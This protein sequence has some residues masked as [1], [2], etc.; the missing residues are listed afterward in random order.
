MKLNKI[1]K[2]L[3]IFVFI[4]VLI[5]IVDYEKLI[6]YAKETDMALIFFSVIMIFPLYLIKSLRFYLLLK[7]QGLKYSFKNVL[8]IYFSTNFIGFITPG[9]IG[10]FA[11]A[12][13]L[14]QDIGITMAESMPTVIIDRVFDLYFLFI[15][16]LVGLAKL[17]I[18]GNFSNGLYIII[19]L[20]LISPLAI[21]I[22]S[23][24]RSIS[25]IGVLKTNVKKFIS[26]II[27]GVKKIINVRSVCIGFLLTIFAYASL[28]YQ[29]SLIARS[30]GVEINHIDISFI[31][32]ITNVLTFLPISFSGIGTR[33]L[34]I[35]YLFTIF[36]FDNNL[37]LLYSSLILLVFN[38]I[39][40]TICFLFWLIKPIDIEKVKLFKTELN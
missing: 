20:L 18:L 39:G 28:F 25:N 6:Y 12:V 34:S 31:M 16:G 2:I 1:I 5:K 22:P 32:A 17:N 3:S 40:G 11:K 13:Y 35:I 36:D 4:Y 38:I 10:E 27:Q 8:M 14:K 29:S 37:A 23:F 19:F 24:E 33:D 9:R 7:E 15:W 30:I 26:T 21:Y